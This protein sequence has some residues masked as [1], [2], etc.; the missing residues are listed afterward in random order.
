MASRIA[1]RVS[2]GA[3][4]I[5]LSLLPTSKWCESLLPRA[6]IRSPRER[7]SLYPFTPNSH[8]AATSSM[9]LTTGSI[10]DQSLGPHLTQGCAITAIPFSSLTNLKKSCAVGQSPTLVGKF[11]QYLGSV[12]PGKRPSWCPGEA[13][14]V[15]PRVY[16]SPRIVTKRPGRFRLPIADCR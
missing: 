8:L 6:P 9:L 16:S 12:S 3:K 11:E 4:Q 2:L 15:D 5:V 13:V 14:S 10:S 1:E 7:T